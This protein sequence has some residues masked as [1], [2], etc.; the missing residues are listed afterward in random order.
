M[1]VITISRQLGSQGDEVAK[2]VARQ[3]GYRIVNR[4]LV[5]TAAGRAHAP[6]MMLAE[7]DVL[8]LLDIHPSKNAQRAYQ[9]EI[10]QVITEIADEGNAL[11]VGR[12]GCV[13]LAERQ[14]VLHVRLIAPLDWR[15][16]RL[17][18]TRSIE[19]NAARAQIEAS[20][21]A[22]YTYLH[23]NHNVDWN[24]PQLYALV[25]NMERVPVD[26]A[27]ALICVAHQ[28]CIP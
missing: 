2:H 1:A 14:D 12:A 18:Q 4:E 3:L 5:N 19:M 11:I 21:L 6:E 7:V 17:V 10:R 25:L 22:R 9:K 8:G 15:I 23:K 26:A 16:S 13:L 27:A 28:K 24:D 20:D